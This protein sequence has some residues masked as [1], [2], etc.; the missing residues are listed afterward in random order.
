M[1]PQVFRKH[2]VARNFDNL[3]RQ[4]AGKVRQPDFTNT[5]EKKE[6]QNQRFNSH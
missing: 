4:L 3:C 5:Q 6:E 1:R 2:Q